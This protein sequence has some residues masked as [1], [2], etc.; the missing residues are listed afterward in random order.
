MIQRMGETPPPGKRGDPDAVG[1]WQPW[2]IKEPD[3][4]LELRCGDGTSSRI[5]S[6]PGH[7]G[8]ARQHERRRPL[9]VSCPPGGR[10]VGPAILR[11]EGSALVHLFAPFHAVPSVAHQPPDPSRIQARTGRRGG[12]C[13]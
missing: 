12:D 4:P 2:V 1:A 3:G 9:E 10:V 6:P 7:S 8:D 13:S 5:L 11:N